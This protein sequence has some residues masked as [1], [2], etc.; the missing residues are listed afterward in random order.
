MK[1][2]HA[3][4]TFDQRKICVIVGVLNILFSIHLVS[5]EEEDRIT[6]SKSLQ[7]IL[8]D[9]KQK[10]QEIKQQNSVL[11]AKNTMLRKKLWGM[12]QELKILFKERQ[13]FLKEFERLEICF[14]EE[15]NRV[16]LLEKKLKGLQSK[17]KE[18]GQ[19]D[20]VLHDDIKD[21]RKDIEALK[22]EEDTLK[23]EIFELERQLKFSKANSGQTGKVQAKELNRLISE[24]KLR[25]DKQSNGLTK[26]EI[27]KTL[28]N[29]LEGLNKKHGELSE[30]LTELKEE[31]GSTEERKEDIQ[32][33]AQMR[34]EQEEWE[35]LS[36]ELDDLQSKQM[37]LKDYLKSLE[38][39]RAVDNERVLIEFQK[40][41]KLMLSTIESQK[42]KQTKLKDKISRLNQN[43]N[44]FKQEIDSLAGKVQFAKSDAGKV[45]EIKKGELN[46][47]VKEGIS[48]QEKQT[49]EIADRKKVSASF[50]ENSLVLSK[51]QKALNE[52]ISGI[53]N[54]I[55]AGLTEEKNILKENETINN[56]SKENLVLLED[57]LSTLKNHE[58]ELEEFLHLIQGKFK[59]DH[60]VVKAFSVE[61]K[62]L[63]DNIGVLK[64]ENESLLKQLIKLKAVLKKI[65]HTQ[66][67]I[68]PSPQESQLHIKN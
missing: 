61:E 51:Y 42:T 5:A 58:Q 52:K 3:H 29:Q 4:L 49:R 68:V 35:A 43:M 16:E 50:K 25:Q 31:T 18:R 37:G 65:E 13:E 11:T 8:N 21:K 56:K 34:E 44:E 17:S 14:K 46:Q 32:L 33:T 55:Q 6:P 45:L 57:E 19:K 9:M 40:E 60:D 2:I 67:K 41:E 15:Q 7:F 24:S 66:E 54:E 28:K 23:Q 10:S 12:Q 48:K 39:K 38:K 22:K 36:Q 62:N 64:G 59:E 63:K 20:E 53:Q 1:L 47:R 27:I 26:R 30:I